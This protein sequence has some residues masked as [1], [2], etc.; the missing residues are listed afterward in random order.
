[1]SFGSTPIARSSC[2][3]SSSRSTSRA[4]TSIDGPGLNG[5]EAFGGVNTEDLWQ[6]GLFNVKTNS[7]RQLS[8]PYLLAEYLGQVI[9]P[10]SILALRFPAILERA[11]DHR[12][13]GGSL[14]AHALPGRGDGR[15]G[16]RRDVTASAGLRA[17][18]LGVLPHSAVR[19]PRAL[20]L[21]EGAVVGDVDL[22]PAGDCRP[23][24]QRLPRSAPVRPAALL[25]SRSE[26]TGSRYAW[27]SRC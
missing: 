27:A 20:L 2:C 25:V 12:L 16:A 19:A 5:D 11:P 8:P 15:G 23:P 6:T 1:M 14:S 7:N 9:A 22:L 24:H 18:R 26:R 21:V 4:S 13:R 3:W 17:H 10:R